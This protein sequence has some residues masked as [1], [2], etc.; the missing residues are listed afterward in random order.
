MSN[1]ARRW[2]EGVFSS[3]MFASSIQ[4]CKRE[5]PKAGHQLF[6][7][8]LKELAVGCFSLGWKREHRT[9]LSEHRTLDPLRPVHWSWPRVLFE[10]RVSDPNG[11]LQHTRRSASPHRTVVLTGLVR[12]EGVKLATSPDAGH[13]TRAQRGLQKHLT[14]DANHRTLSECVRCSTLAGS[15][16]PD[17]EASVRCLRTQRPVSV[18]HWENTP[19]TSPN[20]PPAQ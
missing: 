9:L 5:P 2:V 19:A 18:S 20:F 1:Q 12:R 11:Y 3:S 17:S 10:S 8:H 4:M 15:S 14:P 16:T 7:S 13:R 6:I